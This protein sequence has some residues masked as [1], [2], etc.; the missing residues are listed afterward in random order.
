MKKAPERVELKTAPRGGGRHVP[1]P[2]PIIFTLLAARLAALLPHSLSAL[3]ELL[4]L[5]L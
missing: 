4:F 5:F 2:A 1:W 3:I